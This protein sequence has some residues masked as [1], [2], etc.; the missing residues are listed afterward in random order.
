MWGW[1][2]V[3][4]MTSFVALSM[5]EITSSLPSSGGPYFWA[6]ELGG[7][8]GA[9]ASWVTGAAWHTALRHTLNTSLSV[10]SGRLQHGHT[11][12]TSACMCAQW[13]RD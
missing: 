1:V 2:V 13:G 7:K 8:H 5:A 10:L 12:P 3:C 11:I 9:L 4:F 6:S